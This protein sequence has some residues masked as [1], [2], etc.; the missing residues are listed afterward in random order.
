M[1]KTVE[2]LKEAKKEIKKVHWPKKP[3]VIETS[4]IVAGCSAIFAAYLWLVDI[5]ISQL[6]TLIFYR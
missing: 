5:G 2:Y 3:Q 4:I 1:N 6:F